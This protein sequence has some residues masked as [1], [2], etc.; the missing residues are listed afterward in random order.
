ML[1]LEVFGVERNSKN[2]GLLSCSQQFISEKC[3][4][5]VSLYLKLERNTQLWTH[6][7][8]IEEPHPTHLAALY[9]CVA[10]N[11]HSTE[12]YT[13]H[14]LNSTAQYV[15]LHILHSAAHR[16]VDLSYRPVVLSVANCVH[17]QRA[18]QRCGLICIM[19]MCTV[20]VVEPVGN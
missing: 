3:K 7:V 6:Y 12:L 1:Q 4:S 9:Q 18:E 20:S 17:R 13:K 19:V 2:L 11:P 14:Y 16:T 8:C 5:V 10:D 15:L